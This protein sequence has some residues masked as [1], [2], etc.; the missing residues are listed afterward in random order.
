[1]WVNRWS[2]L[3][4]LATMSTKIPWQTITWIHTY[5]WIFAIEESMLISNCRRQ[6][7][8]VWSWRQPGMP[9]WTRNASTSVAALASGRFKFDK[10]PSKGKRGPGAGGILLLV[11]EWKYALLVNSRD[12]GK[13]KCSILSFKIIPGVTFALGIWQTKRRRWKLDLM[14][15]L[16]E[17]TTLEPVFLPTK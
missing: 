4:T 14:K 5:Y 17:K 11:S 12:K 8:R 10:E 16:E 9:Y 3:P 15:E 1:M 7:P 2:L 13:W 6:W